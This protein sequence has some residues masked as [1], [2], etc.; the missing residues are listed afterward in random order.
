MLDYTTRLKSTPACV[1]ANFRVYNRSSKIPLN[2]STTLPYFQLHYEGSAGKVAIPSVE[3]S[4]FCHDLATMTEC[5]YGGRTFNI[6][7]Y[8]TDN[9]IM[10]MLNS[11]RVACFENFHY[12]TY[13]NF[14]HCNSLHSGHLEQLAFACPNLQRLK[15]NIYLLSL[16]GKPTRSTGYCQSLSQ[17][18]R[19]KLTWYTCFKSEG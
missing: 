19:S 6:V 14:F 8:K 9:K 12:T 3:L 16:F 11:T 15:L 7:R 10:N 13:F 5:Q 1:T 18:T 17:S 4:S 2:L